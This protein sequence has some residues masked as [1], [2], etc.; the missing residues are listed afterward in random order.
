MGIINVTEDSFAG[1]GFLGDVEG[2]VRS[3]CQF[4]AEGADVIDVGGESARADTPVVPPAEE[5]ER[6]VPVIERLVRETD[7]PVS[8]DTYKPEVAEAA[9]KAGASIVNDIAG[10]TLGDATGR[11]AARYDAAFVMNYTYERPKV[12][13]PEAPGYDDLIGEHIEF[14]RRGVERA[15]SAGV[16]DESIVVDPGIGFGKSATE[17]LEVLRRL[18]EFRSLGR[19]LLIAPSRKQV[20]GGVLGELSPEARV[21]GTAAVVALAAAQG[22]DMIRVHDVKK[23]VGVAR[24]VD[25]VVRGGRETLV[26]RAESGRWPWSRR[27]D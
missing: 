2:A 17:D 15:R 25:A 26:S 7:V 20:I 5:I 13:P 1:G 24:M 12:R 19:A 10:L 22:V 8:V 16:R 27:P 11:L 3:A 4:V 14:L 23:M 9:L 18:T 6:V 21:E